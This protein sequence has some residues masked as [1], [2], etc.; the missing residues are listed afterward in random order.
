MTP[1]PGKMLITGGTGFFGRSL[2]DFLRRN[3]MTAWDVAIL[4]RQPEK[5]AAQYPE[6]ARQCRFLRGDVRDFPFPRE[7]FDLIIHAATPTTGHVEDGEMRSIVLDGTRHVA[8]CFRLC[9]ASRIL[10]F[11]SGAVYGTSPQRIPFTEDTPPRPTTVYGQAKW[12]AEQFLLTEELPVCIV[13]GFS[14]AGP[15]LD[16]RHFAIGN[17]IA[18]ALERRRIVIRGDGSAVRSYLDADDMCRIILRLSA[19]PR[20]ET[21]YN[22]G[23]DRGVT[24]L[25]LAETVRDALRI[26]C[27]IETQGHPD[28]GMAGAFYVPDITKLKR[29]GLSPQISLV[30]SIRRM[31]ECYERKK[32]GN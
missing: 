27:P 28:H 31:A 4:S 11:S 21:C 12:E 26:S 16:M 6:L 10:F 13:R 25:Q 8:R 19:M 22:L 1:P 17:F 2:L 30:N 32:D 14:F 18:D 15:F 7:H 29:C 5:F 24:M 20:P 23:S 3:S 9:G